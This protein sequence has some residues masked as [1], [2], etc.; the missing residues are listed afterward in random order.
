MAILYSLVNRV[1]FIKE[2][3]QLIK[4]VDSTAIETCVSELY[5]LLD[6]FG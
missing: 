4:M 5:F 2:S 1:I 6:L 3:K